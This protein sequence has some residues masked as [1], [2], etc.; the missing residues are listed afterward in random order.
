MTPI[1]EG[2]IKYNGILVTHWYTDIDDPEEFPKGL[3]QVD[4]EKRGE[5]S[6]LECALMT[7]YFGDEAVAATKTDMRSLENIQ[8]AYSAAGLY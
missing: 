2:T 6:S 7:G 5:V 4:V 3:P 8:K 1:E